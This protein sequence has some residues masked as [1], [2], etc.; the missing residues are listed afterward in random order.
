[1]LLVHFL[2]GPQ[3]SLFTWLY[4]EITLI[5]DK[6]L[7][8]SYSF[9]KFTN[10]SWVWGIFTSC[11]HAL[12]ICMSFVSARDWESEHH[13]L[14][15]GVDQTDRR[16]ASRPRCCSEWASAPPAV[17]FSVSLS[18]VVHN[19]VWLLDWGFFQVEG[20]WFSLVCGFKLF[21]D[22]LLLVLS[23]FQE[24]LWTF[25]WIVNI[26]KKSRVPSVWVSVTDS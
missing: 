1:M 9:A 26:S 19:R 14:G 8:V 2:N 18:T 24:E 13:R 17:P 5:L 25:P 20:F 21:A 6:E 10:E 22:F 11:S 7:L 16:S 3:V 23:G 15:H 4:P 12:V